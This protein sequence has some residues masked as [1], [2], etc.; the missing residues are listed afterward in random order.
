LS[1]AALVQVKER[2]AILQTQMKLMPPSSIESSSHSLGAESAP[3]HLSIP[4]LGPR[5]YVQVAALTKREDAERMAQRIQAEH[6]D[7]LEQ[8]RAYVMEFM[9]ATGRVMY[10]VQI[11]SMDEA[12]HAAALCRQFKQRR[13]DC[14]VGRD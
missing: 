11:G 9:S 14:F 6:Q 2:Q 7:I 5:H 12:N 10:R 13:I 8:A 1:A 4:I 3:M